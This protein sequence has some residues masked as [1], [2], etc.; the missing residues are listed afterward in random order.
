[1][2]ESPGR[3]FEG[4]ANGLNV[5]I[6]RLTGRPDPSDD[7]LA[8]GG[9]GGVRWGGELS[10]DNQATGPQMSP[11]N[12][13]LAAEPEAEYF[14]RLFEE[15][16]GARKQT[17]EGVEGLTLDDFMRKIRTNEQGLKQK[18]NCRAVRFKVVIKNKQ[19]TLKPVPIV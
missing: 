2:F 10:V 11:E 3:D 8:E 6:A 4:L 5:M 18:Y 13:A 19:T 15:Y 14:P 9:G 12:V 1:M 17:G 7:E 16:M